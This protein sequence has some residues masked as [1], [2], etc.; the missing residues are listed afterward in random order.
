MEI[1]EDK[2]DRIRRRV[3]E[4]RG[5]YVHATVYVIVNIFI[6]AL[7]YYFSAQEGEPFGQISHFFTPIFW[8]LG[9]LFHGM[10]TFRKNPFLGKK[11]E[12]RMI[13]KIM[14]EQESEAKDTNHGN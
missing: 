14:E 6:L 9:L 5:F 7:H 11:W 10:Q 3:K 4:I 2:L 12:D 13:R 8:G 1:R